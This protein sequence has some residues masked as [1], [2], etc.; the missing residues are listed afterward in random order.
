MFNPRTLAFLPH[1]AVLDLQ[2]KTVQAQL[3]EKVE[4]NSALELQCQVQVRS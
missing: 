4:Q 1:E 3:A 2:V